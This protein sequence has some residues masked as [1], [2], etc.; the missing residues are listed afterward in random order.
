MGTLTCSAKVQ[1]AWLTEL[2]KYVSFYEEMFVATVMERNH[3]LYGEEWFTEGCTSASN[4]F[5]LHDWACHLCS[6]GVFLPGGWNCNAVAAE[7]MGSW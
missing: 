3:Y 5:I 4:H 2:C 6:T 7:L 1:C